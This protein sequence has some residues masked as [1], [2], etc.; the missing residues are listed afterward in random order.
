MLSKHLFPIIAITILCPSMLMAAK[1]SST[2]TPA[3]VLQTINRIFPT[4][5]DSITKAPIQGL[6][7]ITSGSEIIYVSQ[8]G[9]FAILGN[10]IDLERKENLT[11]KTQNR[12]RSDA[13][14]SI[15]EE[16]MI[17]FASDNNIRHTITV[18]TDVD[19]GYCR[20]LHNE[21][22]KLK[23]AGIKVRY[24]AFPRA[25]VGS[26]TYHTMVSVWCAEDR[27]KA[28]TEAKSGNAVPARQCAN[29]VEEHLTL[30]R[31]IGI[32]G[33]PTIILEDDTLIPGYLPASRLQAMLEETSDN[34][35]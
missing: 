31:K 13:I 15:G 17:V 11:E 12:A 3:P 30:G 21:I 6:Y 18:F 14:K 28:M 8:D 7:E 5:V 19:C 26:N 20:K 33:T 25:G 9:K 4:E 1:D 22:P 29:P 10:I 23:D 24:L 2:E 34:H 35:H 16:S 32:K 27:Q